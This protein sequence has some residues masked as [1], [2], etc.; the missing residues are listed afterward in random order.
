MLTEEQI[1]AMTDA[2][3]LILRM[4]EYLTGQSGSNLEIPAHSAVRPGLS[5]RGNGMGSLIVTV[6]PLGILAAALAVLIRRKNM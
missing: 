3:Q 6:L 1:Y 4:A 5:A 2:R